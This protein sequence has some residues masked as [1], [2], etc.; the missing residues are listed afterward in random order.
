MLAGACL[1]RSQALPC[2]LHR[3]ALV[4]P[5]RGVSLC[6]LM[7]KLSCQLQQGRTGLHW[8][9]HFGDA[10][11]LRDLLH[12]ALPGEAEAADASGSTALHIAAENAHT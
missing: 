8:A 12:A 10:S 3:A 5:C 7:Q 6:T 4:G 1:W 9:A 11:H 2:L